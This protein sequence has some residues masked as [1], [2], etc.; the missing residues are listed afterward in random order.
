MSDEYAIEMRQA[1]VDGVAYAMGRIE[2]EKDWDRSSPAKF[3]QKVDPGTGLK[4]W[5]LV[6]ANPGS[7]TQRKIKLLCDDEPVIPEASGAMPFVPVE[8]VG[9]AI[10]PWLDDRGC[11]P[12]DGKRC[13]CRVELSIR[14]R[15][16]RPVGNSAGG[17]RPSPAVAPKAGQSDAA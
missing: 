2:P 4:V 16:V 8:F 3:V 17:G 5:S 9:L 7:A 13:G 1:F 12:R 6:V 11:K 15:G 10:R 14:A